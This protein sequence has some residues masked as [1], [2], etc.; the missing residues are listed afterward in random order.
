MKIGSYKSDSGAS[1]PAAPPT[2]A[3]AVVS[4]LESTIEKDVKEAEGVTDKALTYEE[5]LKRESIDLDEAYRVRDALL[6]D[7]Y[8]GETIFLTPNTSVRFRTRAYL[9]FT[10]FHQAVERAQPRYLPERDE[11]AMRFFLAASL[12]AYGGKTFEFPPTSDVTA[13]ENAFDVRHRFILS[14]PEAVVEV[15]GRHLHKFDRK[16]RVILSDGAVEDF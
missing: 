6:I 12:E 7:G 11:L 5:L 1:Q 10:R 14:L 15:L 9:D 4:A 13:C 3:K 8:Y 16:I 2:P